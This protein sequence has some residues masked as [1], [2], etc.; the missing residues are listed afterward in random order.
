[1]KK[2]VFK[3]LMKTITVQ[4]VLAMGSLAI[5]AQDKPSGTME[6]L[7]NENRGKVMEIYQITSDYPGFSYVYTYSDGKL[8]GVVVKGVPNAHDRDKLQALILDYKWN[9]LKYKDLAPVKGI[10]L[11]ADKEPE[12]ENGFDAF[13]NTLYEELEY[14]ERA[15][16]WGVEGTVMVEFVVNSDGTIG[17]IRT[18]ENIDTGMEVYATQLEQQVV[19]AIKAT[20]GN[21]DPATVAGEPVA[22]Q[23]TLPVVFD[24]RKN[25][26]MPVLIR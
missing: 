5:I 20:S 22:Y 12:P 2:D 7:A 3:F 1:M 10:Y 4:L 11:S 23:A 25:P 15:K 24:F 13:Y 21:W 19:D 9:K 6:D 17:D 8:D 26:S 16:D 18:S 14:P